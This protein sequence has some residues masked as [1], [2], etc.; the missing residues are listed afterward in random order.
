MKD[1]V[2]CGYVPAD[3]LIAK[4]HRPPAEYSVCDIS[5]NPPGGENITYCVTWRQPVHRGLVCRSGCAEAFLTPPLLPVTI[6]LG[7]VLWR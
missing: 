2:H 6:G 5:E 7:V 4:A 3:P 1:V